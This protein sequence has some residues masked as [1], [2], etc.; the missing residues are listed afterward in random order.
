MKR[1]SLFRGFVATVGVAF[2]IAACQLVAGI[3]RVDKVPVE[4][5]FT[6]DPRPVPADP[7]KHA[8]PPGPPATD[9]DVD[10]VVAPRYLAFKTVVLQTQPTGIVGL[11]LDGVCTCNR[12][13][14]TA[15]DGGSSCAPRKDGGDC[16]GEGGIDNKAGEVFTLLSLT[17][18]VPL[19]Q[20]AQSSIDKGLR[21]VL[22]NLNLWNGKANDKDVE[23]G[24]I[25]SR[26]LVDPTG[27][28]STVPGTFQPPGWCG[29]DKWSFPSNTTT[30]DRGVLLPVNRSKGHVTEG[31]LVYRQDGPVTFFLGAV[32]VTFNS[33]ILT[34]KL[35][36]T[37]AGLLRLEGLLAGRLAISEMLGA[38]GQYEPD[39]IEPIE[40]DGGDAGEAGDA[41]SSRV[42][43]SP[44]FNALKQAACEAVD[45]Q[46]SDVFDHSGGQC[47]AISIALRFVAEEAQLG[48]ERDVP[49][50]ITE[51]H[52]TRVDASLY[53]CDP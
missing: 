37:A 5:R 41:G 8:V 47:D 48:G 52:P 9:D 42:C 32:T 20:A 11:D 45:L 31:T 35:S 51:C 14:F 27:C 21:T 44:V 19:D 2:T 50:P 18:G 15:F 29:R 43:K 24:I 10:T 1:A 34:G 25:V 39:V 4:E 13:P 28:G 17:G 16:D 36:R 46:A 40:D 12:A 26:G 33:P 38:I 7:C 49:L 53:S 6:P 30:L 22:L 23:V 3:E